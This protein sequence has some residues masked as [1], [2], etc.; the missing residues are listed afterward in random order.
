[1]PRGLPD[2]G[3][4]TY[5]AAAVSS[6][7]GDIANRAGGFA[8]ADGLGRPVWFDSFENGLGRWE[9]AQFGA[10]TLPTARNGYPYGFASVNGVYLNT[11]G[12]ALSDLAQIS[13]RFYLGYSRRIGIEAAILI[14]DTTPLVAVG[15]EYRLVGGGSPYI[16]RLLGVPGV[17]TYDINLVHASG[18]F[19]IASLPK[20]TSNNEYWAQIKVTGDWSTGR[21][22]AAI[23]GEQRIDVSAYTLAASALSEVGTVTSIAFCAGT[24][25]VAG[26]TSIGYMILTRD[27]P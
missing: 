24:G 6:D 11:G 4:Q 16:G 25:T 7:P 10:A 23:V 15:V 13:Q 22:I 9:P 1:M 26:F 27:E 5:A 3:V 18:N 20:P 2:D 21:Y 19:A 12:T 17:S 14:T 8:P